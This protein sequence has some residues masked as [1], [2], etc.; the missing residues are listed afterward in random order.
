MLLRGL[1]LGAGFPVVTIVIFYRSVGA[2]VG[3]GP[4]IVAFSTFCSAVPRRY[5][6]RFCSRYRRADRTTKGSP[7]ANTALAR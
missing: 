4:P 1:L 3:G 6:D 5:G 7:A 2:V